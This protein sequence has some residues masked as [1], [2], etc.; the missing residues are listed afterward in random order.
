[1]T[2][3]HSL[4]ASLL[5]D[6]HRSATAGVL[7]FTVTGIAVT[8][9][10]FVGLM[11]GLVL[12][13]IFVQWFM[14]LIVVPESGGAALTFF[15]LLTSVF[16]VGW[17]VLLLFSAAI[18]REHRRLLGIEVKYEVTRQLKSVESNHDDDR[19]GP[20]RSPSQDERNPTRVGASELL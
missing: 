2:E 14:E 13:W 6:S 18:M 7:L 4:I 1:M 17:I 16:F 10:T 9:V 20:K 5:M 19:S 12:A 8:L 3:R 11:G 15:M